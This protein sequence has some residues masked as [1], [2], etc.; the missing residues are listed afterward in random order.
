MRYLS[1][2]FFILTF[3]LSTEVAATPHTET[4]FGKT[5]EQFIRAKVVNKTKK[6]LACY[7]AINGYKI[8]FRLPPFQSSRWYKATSTRFTHKDFSTW[9]DYIEHHPEYKKYDIQ[10]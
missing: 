7:L 10:L 8:K 2:A 6:Q 4:V 9:C 3:S 5:N 1:F